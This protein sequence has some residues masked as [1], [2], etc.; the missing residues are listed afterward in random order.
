MRRLF[1]ASR[2]LV[3]AGVMACAAIVTSLAACS[4]G[5]GGSG[6]PLS[7]MD[8][9]QITMKAFTDLKN[10]TSVHVTG[11]ENNSGT[12]YD[13]TATLGSTNCQANFAQPGKGSYSVLK[14]GGITY[15][16]ATK[17]WWQNHNASGQDLNT[18]TGKFVK[19][20]PNSTTLN[21]LGALCHPS[22]LAGPFTGNVTGMIN[23]GW[24]TVNGQKALHIGDSGDSAGIYVSD[25]STPE[26]LRLDGSSS[27]DLSFTNYNAPLNL[28][29]PP[30]SQVLDGKK[31][32]F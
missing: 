32:G 24:T 6:D 31:M 17:N 23:K 21:A 9:N 19:V 2:K 18:L 13:L 10:A 28:T 26:V 22:Q 3:P 12:T 11:P 16:S 1:P 25:S 27:L 29:A 15:F 7:G 14:V 4:G 5:G 30:P 20:G 8:P